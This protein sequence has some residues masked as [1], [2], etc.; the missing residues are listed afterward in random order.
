MK[1]KIYLLIFLIVTLLFGFLGCKKDVDKKDAVKI[2]FILSTMQ[3][4]R[5]QKD[6]KYFIEKVE[7][8]GGVVLFDEANNDANFQIQKVEN[9]LAKGIDVLV[10][11]PCN[12]DTASTFVKSAHK[13]NVPVIAY[14]RIINN[15]DLDFYLTQDSFSVGVVKAEYMIEWM[16][17]NLEEIKGNII[18]CMGQAGHSVANEITRGNLSV[19]EK[20]PDLKVVVQQNH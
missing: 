3:E 6:K 5:Y 15:C 20:Y 12:V 17:N 8:L 16:K 10:V 1:T 13:D 7:E 14:D 2:G 19:I 18:I 9:M 4:E 11:Q